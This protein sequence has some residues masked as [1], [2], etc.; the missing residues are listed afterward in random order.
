MNVDNIIRRRGG[1]APATRPR[2]RPSVATQTDI[3]AVH[4]PIQEIDRVTPATLC[5]DCRRGFGRRVASDLTLQRLRV[6]YSP[7]NKPDTL[8]LWIC[9]PLEEDRN[10]SGVGFDQITSRHDLRRTDRAATPNVSTIPKPS[11]SPPIDENAGTK[12]NRD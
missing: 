1:R 3:T 2:R 7:T 8:C 4:G 10:G 6:Y 5:R 9:E 11:K 12:L